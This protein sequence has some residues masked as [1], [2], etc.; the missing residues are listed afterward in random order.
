M[1]EHL[2]GVLIRVEDKTKM[3]WGMK[4]VSPSHVP[5]S[6]AYSEAGWDWG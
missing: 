3:G 5:A 6:A 4:L 1:T 2:P